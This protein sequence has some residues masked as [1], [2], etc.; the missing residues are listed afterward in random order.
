MTAERVTRDGMVAVLVSGGFGAGWSSWGG[1][2]EE[3][4]LFHPLLVEAKEKRLSWSK[5]EVILA[6][7]GHPHVYMGGWGDVEIEWLPVGT[8][9]DIEEYDGSETLRII[10]P[11]YGWVA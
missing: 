10:T 3:V 2:E 7:M 1:G 9:F 4:L 6:E 8:R 11:D 5:V